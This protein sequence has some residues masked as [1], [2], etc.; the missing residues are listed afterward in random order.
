MSDYRPL[1]HFHCYKLRLV[2]NRRKKKKPTKAQ[3][4]N[5]KNNLKAKQLIMR[6]TSLRPLPMATDPI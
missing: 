4:V 3:A 2:L 6:H 5:W 1:E